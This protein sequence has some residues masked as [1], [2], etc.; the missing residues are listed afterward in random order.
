MHARAR[1]RICG[2]SV[3]VS[4]GASKGGCVLVSL[5]HFGRQYT[6]KLLQTFNSAGHGSIVERLACSPGKS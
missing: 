6:Y 1:A 3:G 2:V 4:V 5:G